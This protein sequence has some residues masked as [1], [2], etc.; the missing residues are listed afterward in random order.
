MIEIQVPVLA[1]ASVAAAIAGLGLLIYEYV[2][3]YHTEVDER[4]TVEFGRGSKSA[5]QNRLFKDLS[6][7]ARESE[8]NADPNGSS[9]QRLIEQSGLNITQQQVLVGS[10]AAGIVTGMLVGAFSHLWWA[11]GM[12]FLLA[13]PVP[14]VIVAVQRERRL[15]RLRQQLPD[16]FEMMSRT[17]RAG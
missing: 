13:L 2:F 14:V 15:N 5:E 16:A 6:K 7:L 12:G 10:I 11:S 4:L 3:K 1:F 8:S 9:L 17:I